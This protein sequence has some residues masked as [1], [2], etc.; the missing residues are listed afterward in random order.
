MNDRPPWRPGWTCLLAALTSAVILMHVRASPVGRVARADVEV[1][2]VQTALPE[3]PEL[4]QQLFER[5]NAARLENN[6]PTLTEDPETLALA[7]WRA[8]ALVSLHWREISH[9]DAAGQPVLPAMLL[10]AGVPY[11]VAGENLVWIEVPEGDVSERAA[12]V[13]LASP[14]HR[15]A[16]L[17]QRFDQLAV[18]AAFGDGG[19]A[20][21]VQ[22]FRTVD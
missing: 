21:F 2:G 1:A 10:N 3:L 11:R 19:R 20:L 14:P 6:L 22:L 5:T 4:E 8:S 12:G 13:L 9:Y 15:A 16:I 7:R 18:G 17:D